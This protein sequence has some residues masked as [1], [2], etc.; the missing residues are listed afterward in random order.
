MLTLSYNLLEQKLEKH[1]SPSFVFSSEFLHLPSCQHG[2]LIQKEISRSVRPY[3]DVAEP[4]DHKR[5]RI[6]VF[7]QKFQKLA[8]LGPIPLQPLIKKLSKVINCFKSITFYK[9]LKTLNLILNN[10]NMVFP[11]KMFIEQNTKKFYWSCPLNDF[12]IN[13]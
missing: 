4:C 10:W 5:T 12:S 11:W 1:M 2:I 3:C 13:C 6:R 7:L 8:I 9:F